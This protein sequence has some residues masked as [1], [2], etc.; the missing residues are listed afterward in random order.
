VEV[1]VPSAAD[2][3]QLRGQVVAR[4][5]LADAAIL[6][7]VPVALVGEHCAMCNV[8]WLCDAYWSGGAPS[9]AD[10]ADGGWYDL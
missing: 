5:D 3:A 8:R 10:V 4:I 9:T 2:L 6:E 7:E 1:T